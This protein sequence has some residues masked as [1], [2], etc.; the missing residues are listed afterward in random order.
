M[1]LTG[2]AQGIYFLQ[3]TNEEGAIASKIQIVKK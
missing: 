2:M 1:D 3:L